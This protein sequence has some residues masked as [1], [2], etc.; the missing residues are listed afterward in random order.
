MQLCHSLCRHYW[1]DLY[2]FGYCPSNTPY[3]LADDSCLHGS[4]DWI[5]LVCS[6]GCDD[7]ECTYWEKSAERK[8]EMDWLIE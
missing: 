6:N 7:S 3:H 8:M 5:L 2:V 4:V 1:N